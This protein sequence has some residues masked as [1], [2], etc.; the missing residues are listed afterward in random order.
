MDDETPTPI[1]VLLVEDHTLIREAL[2][3]LIDSRPDMQVVGEAGQ[4]A[5]AKRLAES[6]LC[7]VIVLD[8]MLEDEDAITLIPD[9]LTLPGFPKILILTALRD[10]ET[11]RTAIRFGASGVLHKEAPTDAFLKAIRCVYSGE[12]WMDR[13]MTAAVLQ[14]LRQSHGQMKETSSDPAVGLSRRE[15][16]VARL[17]SQGSSTQQIANQLFISEKTVRNHLAAVYD[18]LQVAGR[19]ELALYATRNGWCC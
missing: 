9:M 16:Q 12:L 13:N 3:H 6:T 14:E 17:A 1:R 19:L 4:C 7:D 18:K 2:R 10:A 8:L 11:H 15:Y 5:D